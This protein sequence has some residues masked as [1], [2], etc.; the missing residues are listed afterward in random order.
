MKGPQYKDL[1]LGLGV[2][3]SAPRQEADS[4]SASKS[5]S[6][7]AAS[8]RWATPPE[9]PRHV[10][11]SPEPRTTSGLG[12]LGGPQRAGSPEALWEG[13]PVSVGASLRMC[14]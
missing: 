7:A 14:Q 5:P 12:P 11:S 1:L 13:R 8:L 2:P 6:S 10:Q 9:G 3:W 4:S